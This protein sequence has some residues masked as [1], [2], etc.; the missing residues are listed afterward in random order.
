MNAAQYY[1]A[2]VGLVHM[3]SKKGY[4]RLQAAGVAIDYDDVFQEMSV[5]FLK[6]YEKFDAERGFKF[7]T[8]YCMAAFNRCNGWAQDMIEERLKHGVV[9]IQELN[10]GGGEEVDL[11]EVL[12]AD[13]N[14]PE[15]HYRVTEF[16]EHVAKTLSPLATLILA[17]VVQPPQ[18]IVQEL[19][20][21]EAYALYGRQRGF[22]SRCMATI[23]PRY[24]ANFIR[25]I[26]DV[27]QG[28]AEHALKEIE[29]LRYCDAKKYLGA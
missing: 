21:A 2:N 13:P 16:L 11:E 26:S 12:M 15:L 17:W 10:H 20:K 3:V 24:V 28:E 25:M 8:Y 29:R 1:Q 23:T 9:S 19:R 27:S 6:A 5:V 7:S 4:A 22:N 14:T 18:E